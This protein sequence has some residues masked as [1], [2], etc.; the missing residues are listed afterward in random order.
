MDKIKRIVLACVS[1]SICNFRCNFCY[2][3]HRSEYFKG[4]QANF[5]Y[6]PEY[7]GKAFSKERL[8]GVSFFNF[9]AEGETLLTNHIDE[10]IYEIVKQGHY[11][12][13]VTNMVITP[14]LNKILAWDKELLERVAFKCSFHYLE[15]KKRGLLDTFAHN[16]NSAWRAGASAS[17]EI[18]PPDELI[19]FIDEIKTYSL[20]NFGALPQLTIARNDATKGIEYLTNLSPN[21]YG[22][23]WGTFKSP[24]FDFK[25]SIF[26]VKRKEYCYAGMYSIVVNFANGETGQCYKSNYFQNIYTDLNK[27]I[28]FV[29]IGHCKEPH[30]IN[31]HAMLT[32]GNIPHKFTETKYGNDIRNRVKSDGGNWLQPKLLAF[33]NSKL[34]ESNPKI[35]ASKKV[36]YYIKSKTGYYQHINKRILMK[37][38]KACIK[39]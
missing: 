25:R 30:C 22:E 15:L 28:D 27:P 39:K 20:Q 3:T 26:K 1:T 17:I 34:Y 24:F 29:P 2:L 7:I 18:T 19:P 16:V 9:C 35:S 37:I 11:A 12:E 21:E 36:K 31:G 32:F 23:V 10:Y 5:L 33:F 6:P 8:G 38:K 14:M 4:E 13:I